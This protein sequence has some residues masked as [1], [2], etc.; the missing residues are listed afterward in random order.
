MKIDVSSTLRLSMVGLVLLIAIGASVSA[1]SFHQITE[2]LKIVTADVLPTFKQAAAITELVRRIQSTAQTIPTASSSFEIE[3]VVFHLRDL[4]RELRHAI[5]AL[6]SNRVASWDK[7]SMQAS[8][9]LVERTVD[10]L[11][12]LKLKQEGR[13]NQLEEG[14]VALRAARTN[15]MFGSIGTERETPPVPLA[16]RLMELADVTNLA[17]SDSDP[18]ATAA[19]RSRFEAARRDLLDDPDVP[20]SLRQTVRAETGQL[21]PLIEARLESL[22][23]DLR[24]EATIDRLVVMERLV[25]QVKAMTDEIASLT[26]AEVSSVEALTATRTKVIIIVAGLSMV[27]AVAALVYVNRRVVARM[28]AVQAMMQDHVAGRRNTPN[29]DGDDEITDMARSFHHFVEAADNRTAESRRQ[30]DLIRAVLDSMTIGV[31]AYDANLNLIAWNRQFIRIRHYPESFIYQGASFQDLM[32]YDVAR[33]EFGPGDPDR[34]LE[35]VLATARRFETHALERQRPDGSFVEVR[36]GPIKGGGFVSTFADITDRKRTERALTLAMEENRR[37]TER[38]R[39]LTTNLPAMIFQFEFR[40]PGLPLISYASPYMR[41]MF[42]L[43]NADEITVTRRVLESLHPEDRAR[44][45]T[46]VNE[47]RASA[48]YF[49]ETFRIILAA[50]QV[51]WVEAAARAHRS[52]SGIYRWDGLALDVTERRTAEEKIRESQETLMAVMESSPVGATIIAKRG[53]IDYANS[54]MAALLGQSPEGLLNVRLQD[55]YADS[56]ERDT[57]KARFLA[58]EVILNEDVTLKRAD[59]TLVHTLLTLA[60]AG[61]SGRHFG[62]VYDI[63]ERKRAEDAV[64]AKVAELEQFTRIAVGRELRM[65]A[66][67]REINALSEKLGAG[68]RYEIPEDDTDPGGAGAGGPVTVGQTE[69]AA[70]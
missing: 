41:E 2:R 69:A 50:D 66:L 45:R 19:Y 13:S 23:L 47:V 48:G 65:I 10:H 7:A 17:M 51:R 52:A 25:A 22:L 11:Y 54:A 49:H 15:L 42:G 30:G 18:T 21:A 9:T 32:A 26:R 57:I 60:P 12:H 27:L 43:A 24:I 53:R 31:A 16:R 63:T 20:D 61:D 44:V 70:S 34:Q 67:K 14:L 4:T 28:R 62:W 59:G 64:R 8:L 55:H 29:L 40:H 6:D 5:Q 38:F 58:G 35:D 1:V 36:G 68:P 39:N 3:T 56:G 37:Q 46:A 33:G